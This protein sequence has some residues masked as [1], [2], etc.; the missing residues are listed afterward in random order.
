MKEKIG[1]LQRRKVTFY[2]FFKSSSKYVYLISEKAKGWHLC[3]GH[4][5]VKMTWF[6]STKCENLIAYVKMGK[7]LPIIYLIFFFSRS[8]TWKGCSRTV[9]VFKRQ[10]SWALGR[11]NVSRSQA[12]QTLAQIDLKIYPMKMYTLNT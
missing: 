9:H 6:N 11:G 12:D 7:R 5:R 10:R 4:Y 2:L 1:L 8:L 3:H